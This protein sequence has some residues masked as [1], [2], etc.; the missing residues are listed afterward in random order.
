MRTTW[1]FE[2]TASDQSVSGNSQYN[3]VSVSVRRAS[4][5]HLNVVILIIVVVQ[6]VTSI[7]PDEHRR[8]RYAVGVPSD[9]IQTF[10]ISRCRGIPGQ[11]APSDVPY[12]TYEIRR[13]ECDDIEIHEGGKNIYD[14]RVCVL[15]DHNVRPSLAIRD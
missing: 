13:G 5:G 2:V 12:Q 11:P 8:R 15:T 9:G 10:C 6:R 1:S 7:H 4:T 3:K 14:W